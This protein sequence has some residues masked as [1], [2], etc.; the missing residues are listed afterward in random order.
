VLRYRPG[1]FARVPLP[2]RLRQYAQ[3]QPLSTF[4]EQ[5]DAGLSSSNFDLEA[6]IASDSRTGLDDQATQEILVIMRRNGVRYA[7]DVIYLGRAEDLTGGILALMTRGLFARP[8]SWPA[9][10]SIP[11]VRHHP[12]WRRHHR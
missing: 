7:L 10:A 3:Y 5:R 2:G 4:E 9:T 6:N 11:L 8:K 1:V 12:L